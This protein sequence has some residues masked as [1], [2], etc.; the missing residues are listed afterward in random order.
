MSQ[1]TIPTV[2][3]KTPRG[4]RA[5]DIYSRL[6]SERIVFIGT[7]IDDGVA[8]VVMAQLLHLESAS[9]QEI[10]L[11]INSP[12]RLVQRADRDLRHDAV[13]PVRH[14][15]DLHGPGGVG[16]G[17]AARRRRAGQAVGA[18]AR[19]GDPAPA[20]RA[21]PGARCRTWPCRPRRWPRSGPR[22]TRSSAGTPAT[23]VDED[24]GRHRPAQDLHAPARRSSTA[25]RPGHHDGQDG[26]QG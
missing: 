22:W 16:G 3:E 23:R 18:A 24:P 8:N 15:D 14:R 6:L 21:R 13:H 9:E 17:R 1:Y 4:E 7:E 2:V 11:Y 10:G 26:P 12:R 19:Q 5:F 25:G 20:V